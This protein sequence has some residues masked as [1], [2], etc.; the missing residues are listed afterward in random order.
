M[1]CRIGIASSDARVVNQHFG[2][3]SEFY[4]VD[5]D[6]ENGIYYVETRRVSP[7]CEGGTHDEYQLRKNAELLSD[8]E[9]LLVSR[10]G[11]GAANVLEQQGIAVFE[12]P[13]FIEESVKKLLAYTEIQ[14]MFI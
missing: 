4:I 2:R 9:Y 1:K 6:E 5:V 11:Q 10:I 8:C 3:A 14:N 13:G 7:V 12:L